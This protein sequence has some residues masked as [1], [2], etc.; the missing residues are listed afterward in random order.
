MVGRGRVVGTIHNHWRLGPGRAANTAG[1]CTPV[2]PGTM[3]AAGTGDVLL[4]DAVVE[5]WPTAWGAV[6]A[7]A[8][9]GGTYWGGH[10]IEQIAYIRHS[11]IPENGLAPRDWGDPGKNHRTRNKWDD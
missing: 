1:V 4:N 2:G 6:P 5:A 7:G 8:G 9:P 3:G 11:T 10:P